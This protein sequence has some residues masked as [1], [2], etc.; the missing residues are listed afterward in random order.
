MRDHR[1]GRLRATVRIQSRVT[2]IDLSWVFIEFGGSGTIYERRQWC[3]MVNG[4]TR[5]L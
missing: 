2:G 4:Y 3:E 5:V 1:G